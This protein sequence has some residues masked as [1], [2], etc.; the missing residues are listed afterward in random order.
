MR[1]KEKKKKSKSLGQ[2]KE[3]NLYQN[4]KKSV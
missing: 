2:K 4:K 3:T 1:E